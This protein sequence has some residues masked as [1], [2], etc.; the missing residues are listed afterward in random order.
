MGITLAKL[1]WLSC[2]F[3]SLHN[4]LGIYDLDK[5]FSGKSSLV[6]DLH[7]VEKTSLV[8]CLTKHRANEAK[9]DLCTMIKKR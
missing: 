9:Y 1:G 2:S 3:V 6:L 8:K 4:H 5:V 7:N